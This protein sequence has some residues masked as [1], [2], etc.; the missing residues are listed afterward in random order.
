MELNLVNRFHP[1]PPAD[2]PERAATASSGETLYAMADLKLLLSNA[3]DLAVN[4]LCTIAHLD[5]TGSL[6]SRKERLCSFLAGP[7]RR[8]RSGWLQFFLHVVNSGAVGTG[9]AFEVDYDELDRPD[10]DL[11]SDYIQYC[12]LGGAFLRAPPV[13]VLADLQI[14]PNEED[15]DERDYDFAVPGDYT[16]PAREAIDKLTGAISSGSSRS[17]AG[18]SVGDGPTLREMRE[19]LLADIGEG[20]IGVS[21]EDSAA[22]VRRTNAFDLNPDQFFIYKSRFDKLLGH[23]PQLYPAHSVQGSPR[24]RRSRSTRS[25]SRCRAPASART[26]YIY[27]PRSVFVYEKIDSTA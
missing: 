14:S 21:G 6:D 9:P 10:Q 7:S 24:G 8:Q 20:R 2:R 1:R 19:T 5:K 23:L 27:Q 18:S 26:A 16:W 4:Q 17:S 13:D 12:H 3:G 11:L 15:D 22:V 25:S